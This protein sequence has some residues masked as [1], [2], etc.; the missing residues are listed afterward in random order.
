MLVMNDMSFDQRVHREASALGEAGHEVVVFCLEGPEMPAEESRPHYVVRRVAKLTTATWRDPV[1]K[2]SQARERTAALAQA[3]VGF[4][5]AVVHA[6][7]TDTLPAA[8]RAAKDAGAKLVYDAHE[9]FPDQ[10]AGE[11]VGSVAAVRWWW[12][13]VERRLIPKADAVVTVSPGLARMLSERFRVEATVVRNTP[14]LMPLLESTRLRDELGVAEDIAIVL[15]Q[16][17]LLP[18][19]GLGPLVEA[20]AEVPDAVLAIQGTGSEESAMREKMVARGLE[21][22]VRFM[23]WVAPADS[24]EYACGADIGVV[25]YEATTLNNRLAGPNKLFVYLMAGLPVAARD[26]PGPRDVVIGESV[27]D[28]FADA[29]GP[30][31]AATLNRMLADRGALAAM[32]ARA[33]EVAESTYNWDAEKVALVELYA[34]LGSGGA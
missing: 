1:G 31:I 17:L 34:R 12:R 2:V 27:G 9:L 15:Y 22:R 10:F 24:H 33:R 28:V 5:P 26:F 18:E 20:M 32:G 11:G 19:R 8:V 7:D 30:S 16:G 25:I 23:G 14:V 4:T 13:S 29:T 21:D 3:V 6:H